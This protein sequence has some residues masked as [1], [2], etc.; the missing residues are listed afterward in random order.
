MDPMANPTARIATLKPV[1]TELRAVEKRLLEREKWLLAFT[2]SFAIWMG[3]ST[4]VAVY[5]ISAASPTSLAPMIGTLLTGLSALGSSGFGIALLRVAWR[6]HGE[7]NKYRGIIAVL[8]AMEHENASQDP[9]KSAQLFG[10][11]VRYLRDVQQ[12]PGPTATESVVGPEVRSEGAAGDTDSD[13][14]VSAT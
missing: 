13:A 11:V 10:A 8:V 14:R 7:A 9:P 1:L 6:F 4:V 5:W 12:L 2:C 3:I